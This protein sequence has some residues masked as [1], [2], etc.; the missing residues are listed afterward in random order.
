MGD[1]ITRVGPG[2]EAN[3]IKVNQITPEE[4]GW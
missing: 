4:A 1:C 3:I 2:Q